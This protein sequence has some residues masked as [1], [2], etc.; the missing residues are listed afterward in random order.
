MDIHKP[1]IIL[2]TGSDC[3]L[4]LFESKILKKIRNL[5]KRLCVFSD[6]GNTIKSKC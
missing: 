6:Y 2:N 4:T 1:K 5:S 3:K